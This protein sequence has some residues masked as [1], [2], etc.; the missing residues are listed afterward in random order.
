MRMRW[1]FGLLAVIAAA[2][3]GGIMAHGVLS[4]VQSA[5]TGMV[6]IAEAPASSVPSNCLDATCGKGSPA[7]P[8]SAPALALAAVVAGLAVVAAAAAA[9]RRR[10]TQAIVLPAGARDPVFRPP[11]FF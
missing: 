5:G 9:S 1:R 8:A 7:V 11:R 10:R 3:L 4:G 6:Q 2:V